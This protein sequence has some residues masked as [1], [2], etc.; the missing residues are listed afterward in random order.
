MQ[1]TAI[2][3]KKFVTRS[4]QSDEQKKLREEDQVK[5]L[6]CTFLFKEIVFFRENM[7]S[8]LDTNIQTLLRKFNFGMKKRK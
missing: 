4:D 8:A 3:K 1:K 7:T 2:D 5:K 6:F